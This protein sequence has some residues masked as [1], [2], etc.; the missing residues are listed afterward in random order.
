M[1]LMMMMM[2]NAIQ[3]AIRIAIGATSEEPGLKT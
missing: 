1:T 2:A 3:V